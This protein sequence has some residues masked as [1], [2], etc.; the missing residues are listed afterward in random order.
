M[1]ISSINKTVSPSQSCLCSST[2]CEPKVPIKASAVKRR[3]KFLLVLLTVL[4]LFRW[5]LSSRRRPR[6]VVQTKHIA[7]KL[8]A[9]KTGFPKNDPTQQK[10]DQ[11][12][13]NSR[14][15]RHIL[16]PFVF[17]LHDTQQAPLH[18]KINS[19]IKDK[20]IV[21]LRSLI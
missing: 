18:Q 10:Q 1:R 21:L 17:S 12:N 2:N 19:K 6:R 4:L 16:F 11:V 9:R 13:Q 7:N 20:N 8:K 5:S 3:K 14:E 15:E